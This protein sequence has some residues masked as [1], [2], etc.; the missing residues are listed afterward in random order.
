[1]FDNKTRFCQEYG[2]VF[3]TIFWLSWVCK[4]GNKVYWLFQ[5]T[6]LKNWGYKLE[7]FVKFFTKCMGFDKTIGEYLTLHAMQ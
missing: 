7:Y 3:Q 6:I 4:N 5:C 1:M 2:K